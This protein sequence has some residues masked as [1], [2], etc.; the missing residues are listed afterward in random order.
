LYILD[1]ASGKILNDIRT[2]YIA[3]PVSFTAT[4]TVLTASLN[5]DSGYFREDT[6]REWN[7]AT[8]R[9]VRELGGVPQGVHSLLRLSADG[10]LVLAYIGREKPVEHFL[11][12]D[13][14]EFGLWDYR[15]GRLIATSGHVERPQP[16]NALEGQIG[17]VA[18]FGSGSDRIVVAD[19]GSRVLIWWHQSSRPFLIYDITP[20]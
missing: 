11:R 2:G 16:A 8:G 1:V 3:G 4:D 20:A 6:I 9:R 15:T 14:L 5:A 18:S 10:N 19:T 7:V 12:N 17:P 13:Y